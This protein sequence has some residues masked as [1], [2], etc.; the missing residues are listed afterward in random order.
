[1]APINLLKNLGKIIGDF[2]TRLI[3]AL[4][5]PK[6]IKDKF[7]DAVEKKETKTG[8]AGDTSGEAA[9][10]EEV[11]EVIDPSVE[12][13]PNITPE[14]K[15]KTIN[16]D[17][18]QSV[19]S[20]VATMRETGGETTTTTGYTED[21]KQGDLGTFNKKLTS[22]NDKIK[23]LEDTFGFP[24]FE[25]GN[26][27]FDN[28][29]A[30]EA[31]DKPALGKAWRQYSGLIRE[32][33]KTKI[34]IKEIESR[35]IEEPT[36]TERKFDRTVTKRTLKEDGDSKTNMSVVNAPVNSSSVVNNS[37]PTISYVKMNT[38]VDPY[39]EKMQNS[40]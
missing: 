39:T 8:G 4:P 12:T 29:I 28:T 30:E 20:T 18:P 7:K 24:D 11:G 33:D 19:V 25:V 9:S 32:R 34:A 17:K 22:V 23:S 2:F 27:D 14:E 40:F 10:P 31:K 16:M 3:D 15:P 37:Q 35:A 1:M 26:P 13:T 36:T 21:Q 5:L 6:F 38:G